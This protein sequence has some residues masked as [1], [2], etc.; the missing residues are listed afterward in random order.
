MLNALYGCDNMHEVNSL[1]GGEDYGGLG[2]QYAVAWLRCFCACDQDH[3]LELS[4]LT[5]Q[6]QEREEKGGAGS[7]YPL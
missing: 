7:P 3:V 1:C 5:S 2:F 6:W 4:C